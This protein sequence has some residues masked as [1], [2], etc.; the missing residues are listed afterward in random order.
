[1]CHRDSTAQRP[2]QVLEIAD[3]FRAYGDA[4][5][6]THTL[7]GQQLRVM[8]AIEQC[9]T[10]ALGGH[11]L[12][13]DHCGAYE[14]RYHSC[15][16]RHC[17]KCQSLAKARWV[18][19]RLADLLPIPYYFQTVVMESRETIPIIFWAVTSCVLSIT[20][21]FLLTAN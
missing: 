8:R 19:A 4:Y 9:R 6:A 21:A 5:R 18:E 12:Q 1:M 7:A 16:N 14:A 10:P 3:I 11:L 13:C 2:R 15:R 20:A 17:P